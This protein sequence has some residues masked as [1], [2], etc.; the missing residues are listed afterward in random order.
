MKEDPEEPYYVILLQQPVH[1]RGTPVH[2][3]Q[4]MLVQRFLVW[5]LVLPP[6]WLAGWS[7]YTNPAGP[8]VHDSVNQ[9]TSLLGA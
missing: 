2:M 7:R 8:R 5:R 4:Q 1:V 6:L 9:S 3:G